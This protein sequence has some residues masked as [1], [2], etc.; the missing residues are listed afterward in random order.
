MYK[1]FIC[2]TTES[3]VHSGVDALVLECLD[4]L[5]QICYPCANNNLKIRQEARSAL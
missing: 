1:C 2:G 5:E 3:I 4:S